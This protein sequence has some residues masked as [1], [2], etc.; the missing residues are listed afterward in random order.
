MGVGVGVD[1]FPKLACVATNSGVS[2]Y[3][4]GCP[5]STETMGVPM[6]V[7]HL[8][9]NVHDPWR[10]EVLI[11]FGHAD[12]ANPADS[13]TSPCPSTLQDRLSAPP[14]RRVAGTSHE[15]RMP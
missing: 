1:T 9:N 13:A 6:S 12:T 14:F 3:R 15:G 8:V 2:C 10:G 4:L 11:Y 7:T 5:E